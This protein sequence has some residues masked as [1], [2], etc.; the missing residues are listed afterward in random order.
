VEH[1]AHILRTT[2]AIRLASLCVHIA[3]HIGAGLWLEL[4][5][6]LAQTD[7]SLACL[8]TVGLSRTSPSL[9]YSLLRI[10]G[11]SIR[12]QLHDFIGAGL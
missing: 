3:A 1:L 2:Y 9:F 6:L 4:G 11:I 8:G 7:G 5:S 12:R 10:R